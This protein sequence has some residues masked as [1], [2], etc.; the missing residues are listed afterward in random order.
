[1]VLSPLV[2]VSDFARRI[3][4][5]VGDDVDR[6][7]AAL[8]DAST[9]VRAEAGTIWAAHGGTTATLP[10]WVT[11]EDPTVPD[12]VA[13]VVCAVA[14]R[15]FVNPDGVKSQDFGD[16][17]GIDYVD[18]SGDVY[19]K[20]S[21]KDLIRKAL[22]VRRARRSRSAVLERADPVLPTAA[23]VYANERGLGCPEPYT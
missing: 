2:E 19:L 6:A 10:T 12:V 8:E 18:P 21:E 22:G 9:V 3:P 4:G 14:R 15:V 7:A 13:T 20:A 1:M 5:G 16:G 23:I 17:R 11:A